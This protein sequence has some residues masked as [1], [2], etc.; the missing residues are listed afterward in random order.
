MSMT[1]TEC[2]AWLAERGFRAIQDLSRHVPCQG[3][4]WITTTA[5]Y[6][7]ARLGELSVCQYVVDNGAAQTVRTRANFGKHP[8][9]ISCYGGHLHVAKWLFRMGAAEDIRAR[10]DAGRSPMLKACQMGHLAVAEWLF[11]VGAGE[12]IRTPNNFENG[13]LSVACAMGHA[14]IAQWLVLKGA[15][16]FI[17]PRLDARG[18]IEVQ[19]PTP[20][21]R[22]NELV[23]HA[24]APLGVDSG[25]VCDKILLHDVSEESRRDVYLSLDHLLMGHLC[26]ARL[27]L[28]AVSRGV[29]ASYRDHDVSSATQPAAPSS[30]SSSSQ[31]MA[32][33][34]PASASQL[35]AAQEENDGVEP[36]AK[37]VAVSF[38]AQTNRCHIGLLCG[39]EHTLLPLIA[40]YIG[41][42]RGRRLRIA[43]EAAGFLA[44]AP[45]P[46]FP[47]YWN[48]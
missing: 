26:F 38:P 46:A 25:H 23:R 29:L 17:M 4:P 22:P 42:E 48:N 33:S 40:D 45:A 35:P 21:P 47:V 16:N 30:S 7:A 32:A 34:S 44:A 1:P 6:E 18:N 11:S 2:K 13:P 43:R 28:P 37:R 10:D 20:R 24:R 41:V 8:M 39:H 36:T 15:A 27:I 3:Q 12:D 31:F 19:D 14:H 9:I 5:M